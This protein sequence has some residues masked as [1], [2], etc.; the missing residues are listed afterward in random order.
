MVCTGDEIQILQSKIIPRHVFLWQL[1]LKHFCNQADNISVMLSCSLSM[2]V[3]PWQLWA[4]MEQP[5]SFA[6][7]KE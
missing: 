2:S 1:T 6:G 4:Y 5:T 3:S 7:P